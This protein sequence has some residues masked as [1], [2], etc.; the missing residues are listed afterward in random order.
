MLVS[1]SVMSTYSMPPTF[2]DGN[3]WTLLDIDLVRQTLVYIDPKKP[4]ALCPP[5]ILSTFLWWLVGLHPAAVFH[6]GNPPAPVPQ[7]KDA[8]SCG[9]ILLCIMATQHLSHPPWMQDDA[10][11][12]HMCWFLRLS[13]V[14]Q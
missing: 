13:E 11:L 8:I 2:I 3:H 7:Q 5:H 6:V 1:L 4:R 12:H 10:A 14:Y 9:P